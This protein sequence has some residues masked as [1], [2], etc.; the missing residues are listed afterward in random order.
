M[1]SRAAWTQSNGLHSLR[2]PHR[3]PAA[4]YDQETR[5]KLYGLTGE[6]DSDELGR[7]RR[8]VRATGLG[9]LSGC[10]GGPGSRQVT[11]PRAQLSAGFTRSVTR[12]LRTADNHPL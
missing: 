11:F 7:T 12:Q 4:T 5:D 2:S 8:V 9:R 6:S 1:I 10:P 3:L